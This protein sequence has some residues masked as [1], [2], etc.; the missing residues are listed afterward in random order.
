MIGADGQLGSDLCRVIAP[1]EIIPLTI[2]ELDITSRE[3]VHTIV[4]KYQ[5]GIVI[6][7]AAF[8][9][10]DKCE[11]EVETAFNVNAVGVKYVAEACREHGVVLVQISTDYVFDGEKETPYVETDIPNPRSVYAASKLAGEQCAKYMLDKYFI[12]RSSG[13]YGAAGC[14]G[15]GGSNFVK[16]M[17]ARAKQEPFL[18]IVTDKMVSP[19]YTM[20]LAEKINE[21]M[22]TER[23][24]TYHVVNHG[25]CSWHDFARKIFDLLGRTVEVHKVTGQNYKTPAK[26]PK[27]SVLKNA[28]LEKIGLDDMRSWQEALEAYLIAKGYLEL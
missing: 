16:N 23:Y 28:E 26:R 14:M 11:D 9:H 5:P 13:L 21:L 25:S 8:H 12:V 3:A 2:K 6:N 27:Y 4:K 22:R 1:E 19:T 7:T 10:V 15:K 17:I 20:D 24:G 18:K